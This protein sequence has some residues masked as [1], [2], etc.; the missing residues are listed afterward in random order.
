[1]ASIKKIIE[2]KKII[3]MWFIFVASCYTIYNI[4]YIFAIQAV[5]LF[6]S[7]SR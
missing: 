3:N 4:C 6:I 2:I 7:K 1:M 5:A